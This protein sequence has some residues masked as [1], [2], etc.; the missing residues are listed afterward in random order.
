MSSR[1]RLH[2]QA[3]RSAAKSTLK[4]SNMRGSLRNK[5]YKD[6]VFKVVTAHAGITESGKET[7]VMAT[8]VP[9]K[10]NRNPA[11]MTTADS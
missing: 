11:K 8:R 4:P 2:G 7:D 1:R 6:L 5:F 9:G 3:P 10:S